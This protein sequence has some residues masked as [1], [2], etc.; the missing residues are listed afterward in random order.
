MTAVDD[1]GD[2]ADVPAAL[3][4][5]STREEM[6]CYDETPPASALSA[7]AGAGREVCVAVQ[8]G[9]TTAIEVRSSNYDGIGR[10]VTDL[11]IDRPLNSSG[12]EVSWAS[13]YW[14]SVTPTT[15]YM[16]STTSLGIL[17]APRSGGVRAESLT[18]GLTS[19]ELGND[20]VNVGE[21]VFVLDD[22][23]RAPGEARIHR[24]I[25]G[26]GLL[27]VTPWDTGNAFVNDDSDALAYDGTEL[28]FATSSSTTSDPDT[29]FYAVSPGAPNS[30]RTLGSNSRLFNVAGI[31][32]DA[33][34]IYAA[35]NL[36]DDT[37][38]DGIYR[39][40]RADLGTPSTVPELVALV[41]VD[42]TRA[43]LALYTSP[44]TTY[45]YFRDDDGNV[46]VADVS[47]ATPL[48]LGVFSDLGRGG[49]DA[50]TITGDSLYLFES[51]TVSNG[52][53]VRFD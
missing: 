34:Y 17:Q 5:A 46:H 49:D 8:S 13:D 36:D 43:R 38:L 6:S 47:G 40:A 31:A 50:L 42:L 44:T 4:D 12:S 21:A 7:W 2:P 45:L 25:N 20:G 9:T 28:I 32:V 16:G 22:A 27:S 29:Q 26:S 24:A 39:I 19:R 35:G 41:N 11:M 3:I 52:R 53:L 10:T 15:L 18:A 23:T 30:G 1:G 37:D 51:E 33:T 14:L 48:Y